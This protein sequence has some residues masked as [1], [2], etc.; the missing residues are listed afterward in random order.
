MIWLMRRCLSV[1]G[2]AH[3]MGVLHGNLDPA[4]V[5]VRPKDHNVWLVDWSYS[6]VNPAQT[7]QGFRCLNE[8]YGPPEVA[9]RKPPMPSSDLYSLGKAMIFAAGGDPAEKTLPDGMDERLQRFLRFMV[10]D[11]QRGRAQDAWEL[12]RS[13]DRLRA[14]IWGAHEFIEFIV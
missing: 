2:R 4:H 3:A 14:E 8:V 9:A 1:L 5:M 13:L 11:S 7:G 10:L 12:Y 6:I